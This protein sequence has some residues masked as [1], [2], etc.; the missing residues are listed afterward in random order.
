MI[1][2]FFFKV[3]FNALSDNKIDPSSEGPYY[4]VYLPQEF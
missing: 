3:G 2:F 4:F 1:F